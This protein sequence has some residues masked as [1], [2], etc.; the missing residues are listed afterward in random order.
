LRSF[1][2]EASPGLLAPLE[3]GRIVDR[4]ESHLTL[5]VPTLFSAKRLNHK[6]SQLEA[7]CQRFFGRDMRVEIETTDSGD[8]V[9]ESGTADGRE[10]ARD[11]KQR[12]LT[13]PSVRR[14]LETLDGEIVEIRPVGV[15][16]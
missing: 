5:A 3:G 1:A 9:V 13:H 4:G 8:G 16:R 6:R 11:R 15:P 14:A 10:A 7:A 12:A 2:G